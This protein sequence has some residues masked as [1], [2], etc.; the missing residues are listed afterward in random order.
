M[1][2]SSGSKACSSHFIAVVLLLLLSVSPCEG[3]RKLLK[4][5]AAQ[6]ASGSISRHVVAPWHVNSHIRHAQGE[7]APVSAEQLDL[8]I[9]RE[10][11]KGTIIKGSH[12]PEI[13]ESS[14][15]LPAVPGLPPG[16]EDPGRDPAPEK[17]SP[18]PVS[19]P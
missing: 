15:P 7:M 8:M 5:G 1:A 3:S 6:I 18:E 10:K 12:M 14:E 2:L 11:D 17:T 13:V 16:M 4:L 19:A 9:Q